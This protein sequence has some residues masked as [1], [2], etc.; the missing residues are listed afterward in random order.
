MEQLNR[1]DRRVY[2][3]CAALSSAPAWLE[4]AVA[5]AWRT[6]KSLHERAMRG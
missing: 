4:G 2:L 3:G 1:P 5:A 6:V